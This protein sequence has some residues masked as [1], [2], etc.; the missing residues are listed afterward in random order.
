MKL[1]SSFPQSL[2]SDLLG[3]IGPIIDASSLLLASFVKA[4]A[5]LKDSQST[6]SLGTSFLRIFLT[7]TGELYPTEMFHP[8]S[9]YLKVYVL[10]PDVKSLVDY[11]NISDLIEKFE[12]SQPQYD[13]DGFLQKP[14][15]R[16][17]GS[18]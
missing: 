13:L 6:S 18:R 11:K 1:S 8:Y 9:A 14:A 17:T 12:A 10:F 5:S 16:Y 15:N 4:S 7:P 2:L 3:L